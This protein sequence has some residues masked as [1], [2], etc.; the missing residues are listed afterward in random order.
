MTPKTPMLQF[1]QPPGQSDAPPADLSAAHARIGFS[2]YFKWKFAFFAPCFLE[3]LSHPG[4]LCQHQCIW[5]IF[6]VVSLCRLLPQHKWPL[7]A[8]SPSQAAEGL[9]QAFPN[10]PEEITKS[11]QGQVSQ[12]RVLLLGAGAKGSLQ[13]GVTGPAYHFSMGSVSW[14]E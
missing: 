13:S 5:A 9:L 1:S 8:Q 11:P 2:A 3:T 14:V 12:Q 7:A 4:V 6:R 10:L